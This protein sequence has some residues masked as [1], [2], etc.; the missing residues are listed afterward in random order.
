MAEMQ[1]VTFLVIKMTLLK[2]QESC[3]EMPHLLL[4]NSNAKLPQMVHRMLVQ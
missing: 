1:S 4:L 3:S 2:K